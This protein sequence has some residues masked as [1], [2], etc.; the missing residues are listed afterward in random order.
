MRYFLTSI[1]FCCLTLSC[2]FPLTRGLTEDIPTE[3]Y[4]M[5]SY[6]SNISTDYIYKANFEILNNNFGGI[7]IIKKIRQHTYRVVFT[8]EFG[9]KLFD[10]E[11]ENGN[12]EINY[13]VDELNRE[14]ILNMI[15]KDFKTLLLEKAR[16]DA[17]YNGD[18]D[19]ILRASFNETKHY[20]VVLKETSV[21][22]K[23]ISSTKNKENLSIDF[24]EIKGGIAT[25][26]LVSHKKFNAKLKLNYIGL[27]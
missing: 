13:I 18:T 12:V 3:E 25:S 4:I 6:F 11:L 8:T 21:L 5:N 24:L 17:Q 16:I 2:S 10:L 26:I 23:I 22:T 15:S 19:C 27:Y 20:Y 7:L 9:N 14:L 1:A